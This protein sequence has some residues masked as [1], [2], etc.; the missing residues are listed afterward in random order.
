MCDKHVSPSAQLIIFHAAR[1]ARPRSEYQD[2]GLRSYIS[3]A[4]G[5][6]KQSYG[7]CKHTVAK[8]TKVSE[9]VVVRI[10]L[11][12]EK[13]KTGRK[14]DIG[15]GRTVGPSEGFPSRPSSRF[16]GVQLVEDYWLT[17][18]SRSGC[19]D[20]DLWLRRGTAKL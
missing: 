1:L 9:R 12:Y 2:Q 11:R 15:R 10:S 16:G 13:T 8:N 4:S 5:N 7:K 6:N 18:L 3:S 14:I 17:T 19:L 20:L